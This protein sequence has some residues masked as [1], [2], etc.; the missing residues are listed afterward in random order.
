MRALVAIILAGLFFMTF[1]ASASEYY[2]E[3]VKAER[4]FKASTVVEF[5]K[6]LKAEAAKVFPGEVSASKKLAGTL[7]K[8]ALVQTSLGTKLVLERYDMG[9]LFSTVEVPELDG[10]EQAEWNRVCSRA[11]R[12]LIYGNFRQPSAPEPTAVATR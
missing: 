11:L 10:I 5:N 12:D 3:S 9:E 7:I 4:D 6:I 8:P 1:N 2:V